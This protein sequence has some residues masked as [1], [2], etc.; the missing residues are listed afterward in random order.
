MKIHLNTEVANQGAIGAGRH[1]IDMANQDRISTATGA[2]GGQL[3]FKR[4][5]FNAD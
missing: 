3:G 5:S 2:R 4:F 1:Q